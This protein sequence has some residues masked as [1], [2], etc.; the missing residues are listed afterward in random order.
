LATHDFD[1]CLYMWSYSPYS[2]A[3][4]FS[5]CSPCWFLLPYDRVDMNVP[6]AQKFIHFFANGMLKRLSE[7]HLQTLHWQIVKWHFWGP[8]KTL[9]IVF[10]LFYCIDISMREWRMEN[11]M[12][13]LLAFFITSALRAIKSAIIITQIIEK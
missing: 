13:A 12:T 9:E 2:N 6:K 8:L 5:H 3:T 11:I 7:K 4:P 1:F 10:S